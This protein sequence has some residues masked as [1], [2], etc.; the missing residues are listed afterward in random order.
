[1]LLKSASIDPSGISLVASK[2]TAIFSN[3]TD[4][5]NISSLLVMAHGW[6]IVYD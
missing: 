1:M 5:G 4:K 2:G 6:S 3:P